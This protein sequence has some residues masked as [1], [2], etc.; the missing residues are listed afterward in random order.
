[1]LHT[2]NMWAQTWGN[3]NDMV[4]PFYV[5]TKETATEEMVKQVRT[6]YK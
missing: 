3:I 1:M 5:K 2:G 6:Q 4:N